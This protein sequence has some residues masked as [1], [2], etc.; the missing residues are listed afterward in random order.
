[1]TST[2]LDIEQ[3]SKDHEVFAR[4]TLP[5]HSRKKL[6]AVINLRQPLS[7][8]STNIDLYL[9]DSTITVVENPL[10]KLKTFLTKRYL[11]VMNSTFCDFNRIREKL[12]EDKKSIQEAVLDQDILPGVGNV[13]KCEALFRC[14][15]HPELLSCSLSDVQFDALI[16]ALQDFSWEWY[17]ATKKRG[18][19]VLKQIYG[20]SECALCQHAVSLVRFSGECSLQRITYFCPQCQPTNAANGQLQKRNANPNNLSGTCLKRSFDH[21]Q[22]SSGRYC[23]MSDVLRWSCNFCNCDNM[24]VMEKEVD[25]IQAHCVVCGEQIPSTMIEDKF[26]NKRVSII[27]ET[28]GKGSIPIAMTATNSSIVS[29]LKAQKCRC[30]KSACLQRVRTATSPNLHR[31]F[32]SCSINRGKS[33]CSFFA[34]ADASFPKC[35]HNQSSTQDMKNNSKPHFSILRRVLKPG[36]N[37]GR[38]FYTCNNGGCDFFQWEDGSIQTNGAGNDSYYQGSIPL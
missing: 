1:M 17:H 3:L 31:L 7:L 38:Y 18:K 13:I 16:H 23:D 33:G 5:P 10:I 30:G 25:L 15:L 37:N 24:I 8:G 4:S 26:N 28:A 6:T 11:D 14:K 34:W 20:R 19:D 2:D 29:S 32:W 36:Q 27:E 35:S 9:F 12:K 22:D 21:Y